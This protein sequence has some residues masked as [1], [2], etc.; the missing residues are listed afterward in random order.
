MG[1]DH[2]LDW[3]FGYPADPSI[4]QGR[5]ESAVNSTFNGMLERHDPIACIRLN[6]D[7]IRR[8]AENHKDIGRYVA[9]DGT[10]Y[11]A[12]VEQRSAISPSEEILLR[13][14]MSARMLVHGPDKVWRGW[15]LV[16]LIDIKST[17]PLVWA[18]LPLDK[19]RE[20]QAVPLLLELLFRFWPDCPIE[21]LIGD[22]EFYVEELCAE[23]EFRYGAHPVFP[24]K[25][26]IAPSQKW[27]ATEG[28]PTCSKHGLMKLAWSEGFV[29]PKGRLK[30]GVPEDEL[31]DLEQKARLRWE[32]PAPGCSIK[33]ATYPGHNARL[34]TYLPSQG[35][36]RRVGRRVALL[37]RRNAAE[38][39]IA[40]L[41]SR[42][43]ALEGQMQPR[44]VS[45]DRQAEWLAGA[46]L[47]GLTL[48]RLAHESGAYAAAEAE[49][50]A[51]SLLKDT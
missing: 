40:S 2:L 18:I 38:S 11:T 8:L 50:R 26:K 19:G 17:L 1:A 28:T 13:G 22:R 4:Q 39:L 3:A 23:L 36:H 33:A 45:S 15:L 47:L 10:D 42:G 49:A 37:K 20:F 35:A 21:Y 31:E 6:I 46:A 43:V 51:R 27:A 5:S 32:C 9:I 48:R 29:E 44:W 12:P 16:Q 24:R 41:K 7:A 25:G 14:G 34:Y 30:R